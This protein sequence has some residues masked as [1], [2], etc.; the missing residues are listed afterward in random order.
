M[1]VVAEAYGYISRLLSVTIDRGD[2]AGD[3]ATID[4]VL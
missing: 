2:R 3:F 1:F 4:I